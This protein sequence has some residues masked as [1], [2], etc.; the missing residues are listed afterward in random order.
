MFLKSWFLQSESVKMEKLI[1]E[2][3]LFS[4]LCYDRANLVGEIPHIIKSIT[5]VIGFRVK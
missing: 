2:K 1:K 4:W 5:S 3:L